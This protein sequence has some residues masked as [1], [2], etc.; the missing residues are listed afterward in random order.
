MIIMASF[1]IK[2]ILHVPPDRLW[3]HLSDFTG[4][5]GPRTEVLLEEPGDPDHF[6]TGAVR[7]LIL[8]SDQLREKLIRVDPQ[9][10]LLSYELLSGA[11]VR[12]YRGTVIVDAFHDHSLVTWRVRFQPV[13]PWPASLVGGYARRSINVMLDD[14]EEALLAAEV[15]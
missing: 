1:T 8:G 9:R 14:L 15:E 13:F 11:P 4:S 10:R 12:T 6:H 5:Q 2:R 7:R 3:Q